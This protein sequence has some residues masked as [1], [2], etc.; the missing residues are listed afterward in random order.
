VKKNW[1]KEPPLRTCRHTYRRCGMEEEKEKEDEIYIPKKILKRI[2]CVTV[3]KKK[4]MTYAKSNA[5]EKGGW[6][7][8]WSP[9][10]KTKGPLKPSK[11]CES[12]RGGW[13]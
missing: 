6:A 12:K 11:V 9:G 7:T 3:K 2:F 5:K 1:R 13:R 8:V 10:G 4:F